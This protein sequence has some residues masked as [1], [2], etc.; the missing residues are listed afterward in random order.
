MLAVYTPSG[1]AANTLVDDANRLFGEL[2]GL[3]LAGLDQVTPL[4]RGA[5]PAAFSRGN[6]SGQVVFSA[7]KS[8]ATVALSTAYLKTAMGL[9]ATSG[10]LVLTWSTTTMTFAGCRLNLVERE[11][12]VGVKVRVRYVFGVT[13]V[14]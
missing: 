11:L 10:S 6:A 7:W 3:S 1:G 8:F 4:F 5:N 2:Q 9:V 13:T 14:A 12:L